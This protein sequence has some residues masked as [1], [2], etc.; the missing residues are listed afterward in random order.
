LRGLDMEAVE[1]LS[2]QAF[3]SDQGFISA[4]GH[5]II[6]LPEPDDTGASEVD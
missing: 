6:A 2:V 5:L 3:S 4:Q 1:S